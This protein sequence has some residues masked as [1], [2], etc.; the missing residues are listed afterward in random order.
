[1]TPRG[2]VVCDFDG[3]ITERDMIVS[4]MERFAP[5]EWEALGKAVVERRMSV[6]EG[7]GRMFAL[8]PSSRREEIV[9]FALKTARIRPG[10][11][12]FLAAAWRAGLEFYVVSGGIDLFV[13]PI[14]SPFR[15]DGKIYCNRAAFDEERIRIEWPHPCGPGCKGDCG[16]C[17]PTIMEGFG[18]A[19]T[20]LVGDG[21]TDFLAA[22]RADLV[23]ARDGLLRRCLELGR[24]AASFET[25]YEVR[26]AVLAAWD[27]VR[28]GRSAERAKG[29]GP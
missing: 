23:V 25:F 10:F 8:L 29:G 15:L 9:D 16:L 4:I 7:V 2:V 5:P 1:M 19:W 3:T 24:P 26:D 11:P 17:K 22:E 18:G 6:R 21:V 13:L 28:A 12:E 14:L 27:A 20:V